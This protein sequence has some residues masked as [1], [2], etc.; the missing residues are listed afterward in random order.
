MVII[1]ILIIFLAI[2]HCP[3]STLATHTT[4][5]KV[6][7]SIVFEETVS[8]VCCQL[9]PIIYC[10]TLPALHQST[11]THLSSLITL[12][13]LASEISILILPV[14]LS[15]PNIFSFFPFSIFQL[16]H[17]FTFSLFRTTGADRLKIDKIKK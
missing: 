1:L 11:T 9:G 5:N 2:C 13:G 12:C 4:R 16:F 6:E 14:I 3:Y 10:H 17:F 7:S 15:F 8:P